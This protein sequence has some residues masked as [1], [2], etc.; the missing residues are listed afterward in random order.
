MYTSKN[1]IAS[2]IVF[3][4]LIYPNV[5][6]SEQLFDEESGL[7]ET[8]KDILEGQVNAA[9]AVLD[10]I[11]MMQVLIIHEQ[12]IAG[13]CDPVIEIDSK[14]KKGV[15]IYQFFL[16]DLYKNGLCVTKNEKIAFEWV[17][18]S[19]EQGYADAQ[20][21]LGTYYI[22]GIGTEINNIEATKWYRKS[23]DQNNS[24]AQQALGEMYEEGTGV[25]QNYEQALKWYKLAAGNGLPNTYSKVGL[26]ILKIKGDEKGAEE[27]FHN[28]ILGAN[29]GS[30]LCQH[31]ASV[32]LADSNVG[33][34]NLIEAHKWANLAATQS[35]H[36]KISEEAKK[37]RERIEEIISPSD[38]QEAQLRAINWKVVSYEDNQDKP[39][40]SEKKIVDWEN[41]SLNI[42]NKGLSKNKAKNTLNNLGIPITREFYFKSV[43]YDNLDVFRLFHFAG[44]NIEETVRIR[45]GVT[46]LYIAVDWG[47][48]NVYRYLMDHGANVNAVNEDDGMTPL[49]RAIAHER[50]EMVDELLNVGASAKMH[51]ASKNS[52]LT[53]SALSYSLMFEKGDF[54]K[55]LLKQGASV[56][57]VYSHGDSPLH[58]A[59]DDSYL[60]NVSILINA[61]A[62][63]NAR[64]DFG[65]TPL[66]KAVKRENINIKTVEL[67]LRN[68]A[69]PTKNKN[70]PG[71]PLFYSVLH[72]H[73]DL[74]SLL[75]N[76][77]ANI[78][79]KYYF[80]KGQIPMNLTDKELRNVIISGGTP[81]MIA[82]VMNHLSSIKK[83]VDLGADIDYEIK[84][85]N[86]KYTAYKLA[87]KNSNTTVLKFLK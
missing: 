77:G 61:G 50:W 8:E 41:I 12:L 51:G 69:V 21:D 20:M 26:L 76:Y 43:E 45:P 23:A 58:R 75:I 70:N 74:I 52:L 17:K 68:G 55:R 38:L 86:N 54:T 63:I 29:Y 34:V 48:E 14:A 47:S 7:T 80:K 83:L 19:A 1:F 24:N 42:P 79:E 27:A 16:G 49:I 71:S 67:L 33:K 10:G 53:P 40:D 22:N 25:T 72:G 57:E 30:Q 4:Y 62:D 84:F 46:P 87:E 44:A 3:F 35:T 60:K 66:L 37:H 9:S 36:Q 32:F 85:N 73:N 31:L 2:F 13:D 28:F 6:F 78:N 39:K 56:K 15:P 82:V 81:L 11:E 5:S 18:K 65:V 59:V 64:N